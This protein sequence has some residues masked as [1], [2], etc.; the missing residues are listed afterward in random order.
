MKINIAIDGH[1][2]CGKGTLAKHLAKWLNYQFIDSGAMYRAVT[3]A[4][5][6]NQIIPED[7]IALKKLLPTLHISFKNSA[8][9]N[10]TEIWLNEENIEPQIRTLEVANWVSRVAKITAVRK[11]LVAMQQQMGE[12]KGVVMDGRDV[13][14]VVFPKAELKIFMTARP[15]V[16]AQRRFKEMQASGLNVSFDEVL[17][18]LMERDQIDSTRSDSPLTFN[19]DYKLLDNSDLTKEEQQIIAEKW[20][21]E[22]LSQL[23]I[24]PQ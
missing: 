21:I 23:N 17:K 12:N 5:L 20:V 13:G 24:S 16:R 9:N 7:E 1:S 19:E 4:C 18:N 6:R 15:E 11:Y 8:E 2:S 3:L 14:T 10:R 22:T